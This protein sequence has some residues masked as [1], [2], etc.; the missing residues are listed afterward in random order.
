MIIMDFDSKEFDREVKKLLKKIK[1]PRPVL[2]AVSLTM[3][4]DILDHFDN[5]TGP[6]KPW[7]KSQRAIREHGQTL[8][9]EGD[10]R[11]S[12]VNKT[13]KKDAIAGTNDK[14]ARRLNDGDASRNLDERLFIWLSNK[15]GKDI[16]KLFKNYLRSGKLRI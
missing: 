1:K 16:I 9:D 2:K 7:K 13:T 12:I 3:K 4:K 10:L 8:Q 5:E 14:R 6:K 15:A 11:R